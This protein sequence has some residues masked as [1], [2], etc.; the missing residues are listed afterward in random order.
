MAFT[1]VSGIK[2][3]VM[4]IPGDDKKGKNVPDT[5]QK[6][7]GTTSAF[8]AASM[9]EG[10][11]FDDQDARYREDGTQ[12]RATFHPGSTTQGGSN[13][14][15]GSS[16]LGPSSYKQG[17]ENNRGT[18]YEN[19]AQKFSETGTQADGTQPQRDGGT[20]NEHD[21]IGEREEKTQNNDTL[22]IP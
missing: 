12:G 9:N 3:I 14:G 8:S 20:D 2:L 4:A 18:N 21:E 6:E 1:S 7:E 10:K 22:G 5:T 17:S 13:F 16:Y 19:E 15:Q 11:D